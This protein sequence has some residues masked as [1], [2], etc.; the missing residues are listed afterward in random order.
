MQKRPV[1]T[2]E[3]ISNA[4]KIV[5]ERNQ[6]G[7]PSLLEEHYEYHGMT[8]KA[9]AFKLASKEGWEYG[10]EI[11][12]K[13]ID[14][15]DSI[16]D[17]AEKELNG[18]VEQWYLE[19]KND[20]VILENGTKIKFKGS[21]GEIEEGVIRGIWQYGIAKYIVH[22]MTQTEDDKNGKLVNFEDVEKVE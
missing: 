4:C 18:L 10:I 16:Y 9:L 6:I 11:D 12:D 3:I 14:E 5:A 21:K 8:G 2:D 15:L 20:L 19:N 22:D 17:I 13:L 7:D 1:V